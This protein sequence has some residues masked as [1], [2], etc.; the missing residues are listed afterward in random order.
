MNRLYKV[1]MEKISEKTG[2]KFQSKLDTSDEMSEKIFIIPPARV[3]YL[4]EISE[5]NRGY[6]AWVNE[7]SDIANK[8]FSLYNTILLLGGPDLILNDGV[9]SP[10]SQGGVPEGGGGSY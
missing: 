4:S 5:N 6:D 9:S 2:I 1:V 10:P 8:L 7:Q 3:R